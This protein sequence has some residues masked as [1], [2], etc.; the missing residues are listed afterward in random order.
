MKM[1]NPLEGLLHFFAET[2]RQIVILQEAVRAGRQNYECWDGTLFEMARTEKNVN[3]NHRR[4]GGRLRG[5]REFFTGFP[6]G[7]AS[8]FLQVDFRL[9]IPDSLKRNNDAAGIDKSLSSLRQRLHAAGDRTVL[10]QYLSALR[11]GLSDSRAEGSCAA[12]PEI[13]KQLRTTVLL[14][15]TALYPDYYKGK[16]SETLIFIMDSLLYLLKHYAIK[17]YMGLILDLEEVREELKAV[18]FGRA[19][20][21]SA[22]KI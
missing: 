14:A 13:L 2:D 7:K 1:E 15:G 19:G 3:K 8:R 21:D 10:L 16:L 9:S 22:Q 6:H 4:M 11:S 20:P 17:R 12:L 18:D 5:M